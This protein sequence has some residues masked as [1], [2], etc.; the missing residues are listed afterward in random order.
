MR[1]SPKL[2]RRRGGGL[3][4]TAKAPGEALI[5]VKTEDGGKTAECRVTVN[6]AF[7]DVA[8]VTIDPPSKN[9]LA[10]GESITL[11][12]TVS[13]DNA[14]NKSVTWS[15][16]DEA[17]AK[18]GATTGK[19]TA[20]GVGEATITVTTA[21]GG[22]KAS[23]KITVHV[24]VERITLDKESETLF[25]DNT[26]TLTATVTPDTATDKSIIWTSDNEAV[27]TVD[28]N[29]IVSAK[30]E[31]TATI[32]AKAGEQS[33]TCAIT[34]KKEVAATG[35]KILNAPETL[36]YGTPLKLEAKVIP[37]TAT[38]QEVTWS[39]SKDSI[40]TIDKDG[41]VKTVGEGDVTFTVKTED[42]G[43]VA[44]CKIKI[45][46]TGEEVAVTDVSLDKS[47]LKLNKDARGK[48]TA[49]VVPT[50][51]TNPAVSWSSSKPEV[52][53]VDGEGNVSAVGGGTATITVTTVEGG[54]TATCEVTVNVPVKDVSLDKEKAE[55]PVSGT[56][57][58]IATVLPEDAS[59]KNVKWISTNPSVAT[60]DSTGLVTAIAK[61]NATI[62]VEAEDGKRTDSCEVTVSVPVESVSVNPATAKLIVG[63]TLTLEAK[64]L[65]KEANQGVVWSSTDDKV[66]TV[67]ENGLVTARAKGTATITATADGGKKASCNITVGTDNDGI[68]KYS[69]N[70]GSK[71]ATIVGYEEAGITGNGGKVTIPAEY[72][73]YEV[74]EI[75]SKTFAGCTALT[76]LTIEGSVDIGSWAF[77]NCTELGSVNLG[78]K[79]TAIRNGAFEGCSNL[80]LSKIEIPDS[81]TS[82]G[83]DAFR[84]CSNL[85]EVTIGSGIVYAADASSNAFL[86]CPIKSFS[87]N[88]P[89]A[90]FDIWFTADVYEKMHTPAALVIADF[91]T[92]IENHAF[93]GHEEKLLSVEIKATEK[94]GKWKGVE[95]IGDIA[96]ANCSNLTRVVIPDSVTSDIYPNM[97]QGCDSLMYVTIGENVPYIDPNT[98]DDFPIV[99]FNCTSSAGD[100][101]LI[102]FK[103]E[104]YE[105]LGEQS[106]LVMENFYTSIDSSALQENTN[107]KKITISSNITEIP[108]Y[109]F[110]NCTNLSSVTM[111]GAEITKIGQYAFRD[112]KISEIEIP[113]TVT[114]IEQ[115]AF[116]GT[117][118]SILDIPDSVITLGAYAFSHCPNLTTVTIGSGIGS[119]ENNPFLECGGITSYTIRRETPPTLGPEGL[120]GT[121]LKIYVPSS[122]VDT[123]KAAEG[124]SGYK[125]NIQAI[126]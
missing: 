71:K 23:R 110:Y 32:T 7:V 114:T 64:V 41:N 17:V 25:I 125:D 124:W 28:T 80:N 14:T 8:G 93:D 83:S 63:K 15:S 98:F 72:M 46:K 101:V 106:E 3:Q 60:V 67:D 43:H 104:A 109:T 24:P 58:L 120:P 89:A 4:V 53:T 84:N 30:S 6:D 33:A 99:D 1:T 91:Y 16:D 87:C 48:L 96:F 10:V 97:F 12:A 82:I 103:K 38:N 92:S 102:T 50:N 74:T 52:A 31:G 42:G 65:P 90:E 66:A 85:T 77:K 76:E 115:S 37:D 94:D 13:P 34:V 21:N 57:Q 11:T 75:A 119:L 107:L 18:V 88:S 2:P 20:G 112:T 45:V 40:A 78:E 47:T 51:A 19:V 56:L 100:N 54:F 69:F 70:D 49:T 55:M 68:L 118:I 61:G 111:D 5:T 81:V 122:A 39:S 44:S 123:Y 36:N 116:S 9:M 22:K 121:S 117:Q 62:T 108:W 27:A 105:A 35:V 29:G 113:K 86:Y 26:L 73:G 59:N 95:E 126:E 79:V